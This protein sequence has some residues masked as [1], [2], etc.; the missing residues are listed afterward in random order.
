MSGNGV[1][2]SQPI[3]PLA[4]FDSL[5]V[6][7][8]LQEYG[9]KEDQSRGLTKA[10]QK[11]QHSTVAALATK[12]DIAD[13]KEDLKGDITELKGD[14]VGLEGD[15]TGLKGD[16]ADV[17]KDMKRLEERLENKMDTLEAKMDTKLAEVKFSM[18][19]WIVGST[20]STIAANIGF[21]FILLRFLGKS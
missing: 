19:K 11:I 16:I 20:F 3:E 1:I 15:I 6:M 10:L 13:L 4:V 18:V 8:I 21:V 5:R 2:N 7:E 14:I 12:E 17:R 9:F